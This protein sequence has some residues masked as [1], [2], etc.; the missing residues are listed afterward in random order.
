M[1]SGEKHQMILP[2]TVILTAI[3]EEYRAVRS[4]LDNLKRVKHPDGTIYHQGSFTSDDKVYEVIIA[5]IG[6]GN[7]GAAVEARTRYSIF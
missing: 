2:R 3:S 7:A 4:F 5:E 1:V 6:A